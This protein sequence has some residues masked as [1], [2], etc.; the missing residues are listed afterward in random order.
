M[1]PNKNNTITVSKL[2]GREP[3]AF[4][5][6]FE[7]PHRNR[8]AAELGILGVRKLRFEGTLAPLGAK[9]WRLD[10]ALGATVIQAC[11]VTLDPVTTRIDEDIEI[12]FIEGMREPTASETEMEDDTTRQALTPEIDLENIMFEALALN[13]PDYPR[14]EGDELAPELSGAGD[15]SSEDN[16]TRKPFAGLK[17][18]R[19]KLSEAKE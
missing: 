18:L 12:I 2:S 10:A 17:E 13:L 19:D 7:E 3:F 6:S 16:Q 1:D 14:I 5:L 15:D 8:I 11:V 9:D 4:Q